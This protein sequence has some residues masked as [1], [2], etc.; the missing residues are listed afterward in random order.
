[1]RAVPS[2]TMKTG[3]SW[4]NDHLDPPATAEE[5]AQVLTAVGFPIDDEGTAAEGERWLEVELTSNRGDCLSHLSLAR[6]IC[7]ATG[8]RLKASG[9]R[10]TSTS[11][12][13]STASS[14]GEPFPVVNRVPDRC[15]L[16]TARVIE[17]VRVAPSPAWLRKRLE[18]IGQIPRNNLVDATNFILFELGQPAHVFDL[19]TLRGRRIEVRMAREGE[20]FLPLGEGARAARLSAQD[21]VI[22]DAE[23]PVALAGIK[24]GAET[25]VTDG[26]TSIVVEAATFDPVAV[27]SSSRR[28]N[29]RSDSS[30]RFERGVHPAEVGP[31]AERL[32][33]LIL[34]LAGGTVRGPLAADGRP[35]PDPRSL[36]LRLSRVREVVGLEI[37]ER[38]VEEILERL[39]LRPRRERS[40]EAG[41]IFRVTVPPRRLDLERE[42]DLVEEVCRIH[43]LDAIPVRERLEIRPAAPQREV[44]AVRLVRDS[45]AAMGFIES[46]THSL[47]SPRVATAFL[48][49]G[50]SMLLVDDERAGGTPNLR[51]SL[52][53]SLLEVL[54]R[55]EGVGERDLGVFEVAATFRLL[56]D[57]SHRERRI[58]GLAVDGGDDPQRAMRRLRGSLERLA[59]RL[60]GEPLRVEPIAD[61]EAPAIAPAARLALGGGAA[62]P[63]G[64][65]GLLDSAVAALAGIDRPVAVAELDLALLVAAYP[66]SPRIEELP[67][68]PAIER[69]LSVVVAEEVAWS[70][71]ERCAIEAKVEHLEAIRFVTT[72]RG[73]SLGEKKSVTMRLVFRRPDRTLRHE[74]V[75]PAVERITAA[76][77]AGVG[78]E[79][80]GAGA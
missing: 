3:V 39:D 42:I 58:V 25:A 17:G 79:L 37:P 35:I 47:V 13:A 7:A 74:E 63:L 71:I 5:V 43:G 66:P 45:L 27:R 72:W 55:N 44:E 12:F 15:P 49:P 69:D 65:M 61:G 52:L 54:A 22:A 40:G 41:A 67:Q 16:Y 21:L 28:L 9:S 77:R 10:G 19:A 68:F 38:R 20:S 56:P 62:G 31:A 14:S 59:S 50:E 32:V 8:R 80:R 34:E 57:G 23:R 4:L 2:A 46:V 70:A 24:G 29:I 64:V 6:E 73:K 51:P 18:S 30:H 11:S 60:A 78:G 1:M 53:P 48:A 76:L 75:E 36:L 33:A 26:T